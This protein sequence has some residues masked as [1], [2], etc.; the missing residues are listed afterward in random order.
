MAIVIADYHSFI[1]SDTYLKLYSQLLTYWGIMYH[2]IV[3]V[4]ASCLMLAVTALG[5]MLI[6]I[7]QIIPTIY[8]FLLIIILIIN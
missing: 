8:F 2:K 4:R 5:N 3:H 7:Q 6:E 1:V